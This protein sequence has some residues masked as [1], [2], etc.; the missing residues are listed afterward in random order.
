MS[1]HI[2]RNPDKFQVL[3]FRE[4]LRK[5]LPDGRNGYIVEDLDLVIRTFG[6]KYQ[7]DNVGKFSL[8]EIKH[9]GCKIVDGV[10]DEI[11]TSKEMTFGMIDDLLNKADP[12]HE[13]YQGFY[14]IRTYRSSEW[15]NPET[16]FAVNGKILS[17]D[18]FMDWIA[19]NHKIKP[20]SFPFSTYAIERNIK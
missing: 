6:S 13:R 15:G 8:I 14:I 3:E 19:G 11:G 16:I 10:H 18:I 5:H 4:F 20:Y 1:E 12:E 2:F 9:G 7:T 17:R